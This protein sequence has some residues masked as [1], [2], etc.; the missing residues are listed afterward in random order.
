M[1]NRSKR[2][3]QVILRVDS[4]GK[5]RV[6]HRDVGYG[7]QKKKSRHREMNTEPAIKM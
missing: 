3:Q 5:T 6:E 4:A 2:K 7:R 1:G